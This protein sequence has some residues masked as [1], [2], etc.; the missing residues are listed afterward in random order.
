MGLLLRLVRAMKTHFRYSDRA[1]SL[2]CPSQP[3][4]GLSTITI[5][6]AVPNPPP[7]HP[8]AALHVTIRNGRG[9]VIREF[10]GRNWARY[11]AESE[12]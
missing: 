4:G 6:G 8:F 5:P 7:A 12:P 2:L 3:D 9:E 10:D 11:G 1:R